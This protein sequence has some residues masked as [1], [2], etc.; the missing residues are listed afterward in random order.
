MK[1]TF[2][3]F[4]HQVGKPCK[5]PS[6]GVHNRFTIFRRKQ[7]ANLLQAP[8]ELW[9]CGYYGSRPPATFCYNVN[10]LRFYFLLFVFIRKVTMH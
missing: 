8:Y 9:M 10:F 4:V 7:K 5:L 2:S 3:F 6:D 1:N